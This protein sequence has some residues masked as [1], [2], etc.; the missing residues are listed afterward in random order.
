MLI[1]FKCRCMTDERQVTVPERRLGEPVETWR[2]G[3][4][5]NAVYLAHRLISP[6]CTSPETEYVRIPPH[7]MAE[8]KMGA[9]VILR[10][11]DA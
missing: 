8:L 7:V 9:P 1:A 4:L 2:K 5:E 3:C 11:L 6:A 10:A